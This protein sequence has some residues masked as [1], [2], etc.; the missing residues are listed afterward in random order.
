MKVPGYSCNLCGE[1]IPA[2][3]FALKPID[4]S[5]GWTGKLEVGL[6]AECD[7]HICPTCVQGLRHAMANE[8]RCDDGEV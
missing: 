2:G 7:I 8:K 5:G 4:G 6:A 1:S 3:L